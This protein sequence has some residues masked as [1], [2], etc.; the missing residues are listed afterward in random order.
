MCRTLGFS[1]SDILCELAN[2]FRMLLFIVCFIRLGLSHIRCCAHV[3]ILSLNYCVIFSLCV[4]SQG[5]L[6]K[7]AVGSKNGPMTI[8]FCAKQEMQ[9]FGLIL[10]ILLM[11]TQDYLILVTFNRN[12]IYGHNMF[13]F[14]S[15]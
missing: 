12:I 7:C 11:Y 9:V 1:S 14:L 8:K 4:F 6:G 15:E 10:I 13:R 5:Y 3:C 2:H